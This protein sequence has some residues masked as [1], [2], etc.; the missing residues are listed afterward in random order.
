M[1]KQIYSYFN[2]NGLFYESQYGFRAQ[3]STELAVTELLDR[4]LQD[5][6]KGETPIGIFLDMSKAFDTINHDI[7]IHKLQYYGFNDTAVKLL[8]KLLV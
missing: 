1:Y 4:L 2:D 6:D 7:L 8:K 5:L 3:H